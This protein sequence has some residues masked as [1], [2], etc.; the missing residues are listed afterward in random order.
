MGI[1]DLEK[2]INDK[3]RK[4]YLDRLKNNNNINVELSPSFS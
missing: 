4:K 1:N 3:S 2:L